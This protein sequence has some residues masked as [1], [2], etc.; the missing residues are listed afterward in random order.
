MT[1][2]EAE[3]LIREGAGIDAG[4]AAHA[5]AAATGNL[6]AGGQIMVPDETARAL[7]WI[8]VPKMLAWAITTVFPETKAAYTDSAQ[9][10]LAKAIVPVAD[11]YGL[12]GVGDSPEL[13]LLLGAGM[14]CVPGYLAH[15]ARKAK[16]DAEEQA[17][18]AGTVEAA[19]DGR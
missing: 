5:E 15:K 11:K 14:F 13:M 8:I 3:A 10:E 19:G 16:A 18:Q 6:D 2:Q 4:E 17:R 1:P 12:S 9:M 7:E